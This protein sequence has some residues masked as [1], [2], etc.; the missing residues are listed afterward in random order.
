[1]PFDLVVPDRAE[2]TM[3]RRFCSRYDLE[4]TEM[5]VRNEGIDSSQTP[6]LAN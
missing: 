3:A 2:Q 1:M 4:N 5:K 6:G